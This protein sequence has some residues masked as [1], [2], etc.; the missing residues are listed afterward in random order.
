VPITGRPSGWPP[1]DR[2]RDL[3]EHH[4]ALAVDVLERRREHHV[5]DRVERALEVPVGNPRVDDRRL[6]RRGSVELAAHLVEQLRDRAGGVARRALEEEVL[7]EVRHAGARR[8]L[9]SRADA[10]TPSA[11]E[12][13][14]RWHALTPG[15]WRSRQPCPGSYAGRQR[16]SDPTANARTGGSTV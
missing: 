16:C 14:R 13:T 2:Y 12:H 1:G 15:A 4:L 10:D 8:G 11:T 7:D 5:H 3:L 9:V 6:A